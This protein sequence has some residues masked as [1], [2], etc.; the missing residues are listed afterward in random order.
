MKK[1][2]QQDI[3]ENCEWAAVDPDGLAK[4]FKDVPRHFSD[5][6]YGEGMELIDYGFDSSNWEHSVIRKIKQISEKDIPDQYNYAAVNENGLAFAYANE[7]VLI[8]SKSQCGHWSSKDKNFIYLGEGFDTSSWQNSLIMKKKPEEI[9]DNTLE[10]K[11][12]L[13]SQEAVLMSA[14][15]EF[16][17]EGDCING[18]DQTLIIEVVSDLGLDRT[19]GGFVILKTEAWSVGNAEEISSLINRV[20]DA[21]KKH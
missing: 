19:D 13:D 16:W 7:P 2:S 15:F 11:K 6:W 21:V 12:D 14:K 8:R 10:N 20:K 1:L 4:G 5:I 3:P 9:M 18:E 17:Q